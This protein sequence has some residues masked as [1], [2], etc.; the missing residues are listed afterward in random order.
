M[1]Q[2]L[3]SDLAG[4]KVTVAGLGTF[5]G[6]VAAAKY[7]IR[8]GA[9]VTVTDLKTA[10]DLSES[11][12]ELEGTG[13]R[14]ALGGHREEDF[15]G[16]DLV[17][18]SPAI[19]ET[20]PY[21]KAAGA[22][23]VPVTHETDLFF[24][25]CRAP[26][27]GVTGSN[28]KSTTAALLAHILRGTPEGRGFGRI[29]LGGNIGRSLLLEAEQ[30]P[31]G[32]LVVLELSSFQLDDLGEL[33]MSPHGAVV[34]NLSPNHL[35]RHGTFEA[36]AEA[37]RQITAH[38]SEEDF[39]VLNADDRNLSGWEETPAYVRFFGKDAT[40]GKDGVYI[41][42][43]EFVSINGGERHTA[44]LGEG[45]KLRGAHNLANLAA[46]LAAAGELGADLEE[47]LGAAESFEPLEHRLEYVATAGG[48]D[49]YNDSIAT[50]PEAAAAG[51]GSFERP[52]V[53]IAGG[54]DKGIDL[55]DFAALAA[56]RVKA[57]VATGATGGAI[58]SAA[59]AGNAGLHAELRRGFDEAVEAAFEAARPG[60]VVL[61]SPACASYDQFG[62]FAERGERFR[63]L[64]RRLAR[65]GR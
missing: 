55:S 26:I 1:R 52:V 29:H 25:L 49:F 63:E 31:P 2:L 60:D 17:V 51:L 11:V 46:A 24:L 14:L 44:R 39:L 33:G 62:N 58:L 37:K 42:G 10:E 7:F 9:K 50:T 21:L 23:G 20:S 56:A 45:W 3:Q 64:A 59:L 54:Y 22:A 53:L 41:S 19:P 15:T 47:A 48:V 8:R 43:R 40:A 5:G 27:V 65:G 38:Q 13:A 28:G 30:I 36:Y 12:R 34:T 35:H 6:Q 18:A 57:L 32:N 4:A 16:A 61:L